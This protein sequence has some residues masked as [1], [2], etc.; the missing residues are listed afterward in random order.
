[1]RCATRIADFLAPM[2]EK[3]AYYEAH[4]DEVKDILIDGEKRARR[5]AQQTMAEV[6]SAMK[7]GE[8][9]RIVQMPVALP[10]E[11]SEVIFSQQFDS[12]LRN[13]IEEWVQDA[14][15]KDF[16]AQPNNARKIASKLRN[17]TKTIED[18]IGVQRD[19]GLELF[20]ARIF[21]LAGCQVIYEPS[22]KGPD[23]LFKLDHEQYFC[24]VRRIRENLPESQNK[25]EHYDFDPKDFRKISD[26]ICEKF[27]KFEI[28]H[29]NIIYIRSN[30]FPEDKSYL[31]R[32]MDELYQKAAN[33]ETNF[34]IEKKFK[35]EQDFL[36]R[37]SACS[38]IILED[39]WA[40]S[41]SLDARDCIY[42]NERSNYP[43]SENMIEVILKA[44]AIPFRVIPQS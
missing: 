2:R 12:E 42:Q 15:F 17:A 19:V 44:M 41:N 40:R 3:R 22:K 35:D 8:V 33:R 39:V 5:E 11:I 7:L 43:L 16:L 18:G 29:P 10:Q 9:K 26:I 24:E 37:S 32:A 31:K 34:F 1:M 21:L 13:R 4:P 14:V 36:N 6:R 20:V 27:L 38:A 25:F 30:R 28:G 23:F